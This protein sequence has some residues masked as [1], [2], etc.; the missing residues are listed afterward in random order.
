MRLTLG[1]IWQ[2]AFQS[3]ASTIKRHTAKPALAR[4][5]RKTCS[6]GYA[7]PRSAIII[8]FLE[9]TLRRC[10]RVGLTRSPPR[11]AERDAVPRHHRACPQQQAERGFLRL[12]AAEG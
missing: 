10:R 4:T 12:L 11:R 6:A 9:F 5:A 2:R 3:S 7:A 8:I 1:M